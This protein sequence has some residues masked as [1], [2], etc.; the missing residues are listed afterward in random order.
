MVISGDFYLQLYTIRRQMMRAF[1]IVT[2]ETHIWEVQ[3][4]RFSEDQNA[5]GR[6]G[7]QMTSLSQDFNCPVAHMLLY[8]ALHYEIMTFVSAIV[9]GT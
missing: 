1:L 5:G 2:E 9:I 4:G 8:S 3:Q 6:C 7:S